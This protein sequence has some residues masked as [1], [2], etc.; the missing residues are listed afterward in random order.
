MEESI[1]YCLDTL[2]GTKFGPKIKSVYFDVSSI[3]W[4]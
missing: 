4:Q 1:I 2:D 3:N